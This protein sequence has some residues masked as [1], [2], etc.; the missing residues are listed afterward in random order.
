MLFKVKKKKKAWME[1]HDVK[2]YFSPIKNK[3]DSGQWILRV[4][5]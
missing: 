5:V 1:F 4:R 2:G 3:L